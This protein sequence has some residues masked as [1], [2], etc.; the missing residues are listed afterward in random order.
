MQVEQL[1]VECDGALL[2]VESRGQGTPVLLIQGG[3][4]EA[5]ATEQLATALADRFCVISYDRRGLSRSTTSSESDPVTMARHAADAGAVLAAS[6]SEPTHVVGASIGALIG[7]HLV[8]L[9]P[10]RVAT[11]VAHEPPMSAVVLD[12]VREAALDQVAATAQEDVLAAIRQMGS[13]TGARDSMEDGARPAPPAGDLMANLQHFFERD[14]P[15][16]RRSALVA[17]DLADSAKST[18][19]ILT[20][21]DLSRGQWEYRCAE[22][23]ASDLG[24]PFAELPGGHNGLVSHPTAT[25]AAI[26]RI[27]D[28]VAL[29]S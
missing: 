25:A 21:G 5:G 26:T 29:A 22:Q 19:I 10:H 8:A 18:N 15:A 23:F 27:L 1:E 4:S 9:E 12:P 13:L 7:L 14:F 11:L 2:Y 16:V 17:E 6:T 20:G 24:V 28:R 3:I